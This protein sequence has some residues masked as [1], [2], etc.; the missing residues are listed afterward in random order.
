MIVTEMPHA[1]MLNISESGG[2][3]ERLFR[4]RT[5]WRGAVYGRGLRGNV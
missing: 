3:K 4:L 2:F 1:T 5:M